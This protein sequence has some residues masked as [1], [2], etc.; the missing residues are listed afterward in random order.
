LAQH[1]RRRLRLMHQEALRDFQLDARRLHAGSRERAL[2]S[3]KTLE[4]RFAKAWGGKR[5]VTGRAFGWF[6]AATLVSLK[7]QGQ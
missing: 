1:R 3:R 2:N 7:C 6:P 4:V 5:P